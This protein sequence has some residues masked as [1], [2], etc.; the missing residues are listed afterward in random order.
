V[1][2]EIMNTFKILFAE[3]WYRKL[4][5]VLSLFAVVV[6]VTLFVAGPMLVEAYQTE[7]ATEV[8]RMEDQVDELESGVAD[9]RAGMKRVEDETAA[10]LDY[11]KEETRKLMIK[12][13]FNLLIVHGD[14]N[15]S[16]FWASDFAAKDMPQEYVDRLA[17]NPQLTLITHLVA[18]LQQRIEWEKRKVLLVGYLPET[19][20]SHMRK[21]APMG[22]NVEPGTVLLGYELG[23][24]R[25]VDETISVLDKEFRIAGIL[26][27]KGSKEDITIAMHLKDAQ[28]LLGKPDRINQILALGCNCADASLPGIR[29]QLGEA[30]PG[31]RITEHHSIALARAE[32]RKTVAG[33]Q[34]AILAGMGENLHQREEILEERKVVLAEMTESRARIERIM[35]TLADVITPLVVLVCAIWV[36]LLALANVRQRSTEIGLLRALG[37]GS[38]MIAGLFLGKAV[39]VGLI[40][41]AVGF[42]F[43]TWMAQFLGQSTLE[44]ASGYF[45][46][47]IDILVYALIGAPLLSALASYLPTLFALIQDPAVVL[48]E[49]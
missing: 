10:R 32:Q 43:G 12:M 28:E 26:G 1:D 16:D 20:Q 13:G 6:A 7:T 35:V 22:Y 45:D 9:M 34:A 47:R 38:G 21:K 15:M 14:T 42:L 8:D 37:K 23:V 40:G 5:F 17:S 46:P 41:A 19:T 30:L 25:K 33:E 18:T 39:L 27:E 36:G 4:N 31:T 48:R 44:V 2:P 29:E 3:I 24:D 49:M 11:L